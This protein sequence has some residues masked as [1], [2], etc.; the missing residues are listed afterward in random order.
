MISGSVLIKVKQAVAV[1]HGGSP[2]VTCITF[3][4]LGVEPPCCGG[5]T[6]LRWDVQLSHHCHSV[7][8]GS[9]GWK[10]YLAIRTPCFAG[11]LS[12]HGVV[13]KMG[14][15]VLALI[16]LPA[17]SGVPWEQT[18][19]ACSPPTCPALVLQTKTTRK[20]LSWGKTV[21]SQHFFYH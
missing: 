7:R 1:A 4:L 16:P 20:P 13:V 6:C 9:L 10:P 21:H 2:K 12:S 19:L 15:L 5:I 3:N 17:S 18:P 14:T 8:E 11:G